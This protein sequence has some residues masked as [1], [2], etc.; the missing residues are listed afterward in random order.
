MVGYLS[1]G[2]DVKSFQFLQ[3]FDQIQ[4][5]IVK[6]LSIIGAN[7]NSFQF[8]QSFDQFRSNTVRYL[9]W[10]ETLI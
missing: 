3:S 10:T 9:I 7:V 4:S 8:S 2:V 6:H 5:Y 1:R